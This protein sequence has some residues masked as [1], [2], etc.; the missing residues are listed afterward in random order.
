MEAHRSLRW[1]NGL[2]RVRKGAAAVVFGEHFARA[3]LRGRCGGGAARAHG[4]LDRGTRG[5]RQLGLGLG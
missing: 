5:H 3:V 1:M 2:D 4:G